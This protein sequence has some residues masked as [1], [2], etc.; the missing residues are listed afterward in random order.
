[1][2]DLRLLMALALESMLVIM[3]CIIFVWS[4]SLEPLAK[5]SEMSVSEAGVRAPLT[6]Q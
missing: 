3:Y 4:I 6:I 2:E 1:M 5:A